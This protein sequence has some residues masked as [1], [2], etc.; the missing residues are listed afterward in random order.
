MGVSPTIVNIATKNGQ[1]YTQKIEI[2]Y[3]SPENPMTMQDMAN[4]LKACAAN[5]D[6]DFSN[7]EIDE[8]SSMC[9]N[10]EDLNDVRAITRSLSAPKVWS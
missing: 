8:L 9:M 2:A 7:T 6:G 3:G 10:L 4:K 5:A 1:N